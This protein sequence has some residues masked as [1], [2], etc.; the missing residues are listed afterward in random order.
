MS[1]AER[2]EGRLDM[3]RA[4]RKQ[5]KAGEQETIAEIAKAKAQREAKRTCLE[6]AQEGR[7]E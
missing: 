7:V 2:K 1:R 3:A 4:I 5:E 6:T